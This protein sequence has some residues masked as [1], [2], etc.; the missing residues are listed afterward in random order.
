[1]KC[2]LQLPDRLKLEINRAVYR[3]EVLEHKLDQL[4]WECTLRCNLSCLHCGSDC[5]TTA[6]T[7]DMPLEDFLKV[8]DNRPSGLDPSKVM[9]VT[10]GGEPLVRPDILHCGAEIKR[11][12][13]GWGMVTNGMLLTQERL[14]QLLNTGLDSLAMSF[15]GFEP[16]HNWMRG[17]ELSYARADAAITYLTRTE[18][19]SWDL[20]TCVNRR[21][22]SYISQFSHYLISKGVKNWRI[23]TIAPMGRATENPDLMLSDEEYIRLME[24]IEETRIEGKIHLNYSCEGFLGRYEGHVRD[25]MYTCL[26][27]VSVASVLADGS[28]SGCLSIRSSLHQG[29]IYKDDFWQVWENGFKPYRNRSWMKHDACADC[30]AWRFCKG[31]PMHLRDEEGHMLSCNYRKIAGK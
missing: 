22:L 14:G 16:E 28:I 6:G 3:T 24:F 10:T 1:M 13:W 21:N 26:A 31:G 19:L 29:N 20:I 17:S 9:V 5:R 18:G 25:A 23:F 15:D 11:R 2:G 30:D 7:A 8:L 12:G 4:F 27:G